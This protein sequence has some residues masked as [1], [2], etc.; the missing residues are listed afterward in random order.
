MTNEAQFVADVMLGKLTKWLRVMGIDVM[1]DPDASMHSSCSV[2][3]AA[4]ESY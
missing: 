4:G 1:Y 2:Q 3:S